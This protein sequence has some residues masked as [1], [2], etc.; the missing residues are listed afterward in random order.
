MQEAHMV[1]ENN[2]TWTALNEKLK[3]GWKVVKCCAVETSEG[4]D[5]EI[6]VVIDDGK[7]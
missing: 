2:G 4:Y 6:F 3:K 1:V 7:V 5:T